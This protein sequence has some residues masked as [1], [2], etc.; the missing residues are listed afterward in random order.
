MGGS[1]QR[2]DVSPELL[3]EL[4]SEVRRVRKQ[5]ERVQRWLQE[6]KH[7]GVLGR[8]TDPRS[9]AEYVG[10]RPSTP[11]NLISPAMESTLKAVDALENAGT[12]VEADSVSAA[13][14]RSKTRESEYLSFLSR[15]GALTQER[16]GHRILYRR[17]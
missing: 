4:L 16:R 7:S 11:S 14:G 3:R 13:T 9:S 5:N 17:N 12:P 10:G 15:I 6:L 8:T 1:R 2:D